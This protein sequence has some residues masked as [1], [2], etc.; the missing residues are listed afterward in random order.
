MPR[1]RDAVWLSL[2]GPLLFLSTG[3]GG[4][5]TPFAFV[6]IQGGSVRAI[7]SKGDAPTEN[8]PREV[9][10]IGCD[11]VSAAK[12]S[13]KGWTTGRSTGKDT[14]NKN[15]RRANN[16]EGD[17]NVGNCSVTPSP[18][19]S[20]TTDGSPTSSGGFVLLSQAAT[21]PAPTP[22]ADGG[23]GSLET[24]PAPPSIPLVLLFPDGRWQQFNLPKLAV[25]IDEPVE[26]A[27]W[28]LHL[29]ETLGG[30]TAMSV[31]GPP[32]AV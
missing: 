30:A 32:V 25:E 3:P 13:P 20:P 7:H 6:Y 10:E 29:N 12:W 28:L 8:S 15:A 19:P 9:P 17:T 14:T 22:P 24:T 21:A 5:R 23:F 31:S 18:A 26:L 4:S 1:G 16:D 27:S 11:P 2:C